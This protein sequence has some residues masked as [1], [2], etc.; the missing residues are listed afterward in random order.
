MGGWADGRVE[1]YMKHPAFFLFCQ[2]FGGAADS[3]AKSVS[4]RNTATS[5]RSPLENGD[6]KG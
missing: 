5:A 4:V 2:G 3:P 6:P 1:V